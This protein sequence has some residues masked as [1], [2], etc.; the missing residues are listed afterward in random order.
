[1]TEKVNITGGFA[2]RKLN[3]KEALEMIIESTL[4]LLIVKDRGKT[5]I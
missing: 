1:M 4:L 2:D 5:V 3:K